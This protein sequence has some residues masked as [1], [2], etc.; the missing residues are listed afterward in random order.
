MSGKKER[1]S[2]YTASPTKQAKPFFF[3]KSLSR[4]CVIKR[5]GNNKEIYFFYIFSFFT[6]LYFTL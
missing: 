1:V 4:V 2:D 5:R 6:L 3:K